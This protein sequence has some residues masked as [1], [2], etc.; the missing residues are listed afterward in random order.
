MPLPVDGPPHALVGPHPAQVVAASSSMV[1]LVVPPAAEGGT[2]SVRFTEL[3]GE[4][5][6]LEVARVLATGIHQVD[7][8]A[9][10]AQG[11]LYVT[12]SGGRE[13]KVPVPLYRVALDGTREPISVEIANP[14][15]MALGPDGALYISSRFEGHVYRLL[16]DRAEIYATE[17]GVPTGLA[18][19]PDGSLFVGDRSG[20][21]LR[22]S[23]SRQVEN[24]A[25]LP[26]S[27]AAF[28][29][30]FGPDGCLY[31]TAPTL[32]THDPVYRITPDRL[33]DVFCDGFG[34]PQGLAFDPE[35]ALHVVDALAGSAGLYRL[36]IGGGDPAPE[37]VVA[38]PA[39]IGVAIDTAGGIVL[40]SNDTVWRLD[41]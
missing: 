33:V 35:G 32:S 14:T 9:F 37:L 21:I 8:P 18:F 1:R 12:Q 17:L 6:Y 27:V 34:R 20:S 4:T 16:D 39:L 7:S 28:H 38:A 24:F 26:G 15:S 11:R 3:P 41:V 10:D 19:A 25:T 31:V 36:T 29:L 23:P 30:A 22:V 5:A 2:M 13:T 40:A